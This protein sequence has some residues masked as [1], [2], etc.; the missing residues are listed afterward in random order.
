MK[1]PSS[2]RFMTRILWIGVAGLFAVAEVVAVLAFRKIP[3]DHLFPGLGTK[4][5]IVFIVALPMAAGVNGYYSARRRLSS[6]DGD[7]RSVLSVQ[8]LFTIITA[9]VALLVCIGPLAEA[10][11]HSLR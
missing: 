8:F 10:L 1:S 7:V 11:R 4:Y 9:Y 3:A 5:W 6:V 2:L